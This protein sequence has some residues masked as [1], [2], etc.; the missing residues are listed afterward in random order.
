ML[1]T[2]NPLARPRPSLLP[3]SPPAG[4]FA[5][6]LGPSV[7][8]LPY[9]GPVAARAVM[10]DHELWLHPSSL[11]GRGLPKPTLADRVSSRAAGDSRRKG[12]GASQQQQQ[13]V[14]AEVDLCVGTCRLFSPLP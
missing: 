6:W 12:P 1:T 9:Y 2:S 11:E 13:A 10:H 7:D 5:F 8:V 3:F 14:A 4:E